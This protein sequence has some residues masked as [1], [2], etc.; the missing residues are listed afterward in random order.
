MLRPLTPAQYLGHVRQLAR[1]DF[2]MSHQK[3]QSIRLRDVI[4]CA[5]GGLSPGDCLLLITR[6]HG[7]SYIVATLAAI[8]K[9]EE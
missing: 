5:E 4:Q 8:A 6:P 1:L 9:R 2:N 3:A 7:L